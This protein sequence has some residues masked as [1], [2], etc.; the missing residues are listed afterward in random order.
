MGG[1]S[2]EVKPILLSTVLST[3]GS[4]KLTLALLPDIARTV[5]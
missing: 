5:A 3:E 1:V 2:E 4:G